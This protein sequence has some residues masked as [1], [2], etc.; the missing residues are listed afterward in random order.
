MEPLLTRTK[1]APTMK[2]FDDAVERG[3]QDA[4]RNLCDIAMAKS[5]ELSPDHPSQHLY[6]RLMRYCEI[7]LEPVSESPAEGEEKIDG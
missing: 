7:H 3:D 4:L 1:N 6:G 2:D 5:A